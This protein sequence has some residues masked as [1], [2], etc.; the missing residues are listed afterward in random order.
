MLNINYNHTVDG[1]TGTL[2]TEPDGSQRRIVFFDNL[3]Y[4]KTDTIGFGTPLAQTFSF[5]R[6]LSSGRMTAR[7]D[8]LGRR[9]TYQY[10]ADGQP[11]QITYLAGTPQ[12]RSVK[13]AYNADSD[14]IRITDPLNRVTTL[15]YTN[16]CLTSIKNPLNQTTKFACNIAGQ[17]TSITDPLNQI[18][19]MSYRDYDLETIT[20]AL[21]RKITFRYDTLGRPVAVQDAEG[22]ISRRGYDL[23]GNVNKVIDPTGSITN[24]AFDGN[25]NLLAV[26]LPHGNGVT[27]TYDKRDRL[28]SRIDGLT[29]AEA[30]TY[31]P[32][33]RVTRYTDRKGQASSYSYDVL[34]RPI[35]TTF[36]DNTTIS[37]EYDA[38]DRL[39]KLIDSQT[40]TLSWEYNSFDEVLK[41][42]MP[43]GA[44]T[45]NYDK[46]GRR[47]EMTPAAQAKITYS[48]D[49]A[50]RLTKLVQGSDTVQHL[51]DAAG[52]MTQTT[53]PNG[54]KAGYAYNKANQ[55]T[56]IAWLKADGSALGDLGYG[57]N[58]VGRLVAQTGSFASQQLPT[59]SSGAN[60]FD[61]NQRQTQLDGKALQYDKNGN[62]TDDGTRQYVWNA[63]DQLVQI[64]QGTTVISTFQYD[65]LGRRVN[66]VE[67][68]MNVTYL[69]DGADPVQETTGAIVNPI[70]TGLGID[71][72]YARNDA[73]GRTYFLT[74]AL[75][76]TRALTNA[77][78]NI[79]NRY[80][81]DVY[82]GS[83]KQ[84]ASGFSNPYQYTGRER[85]GSG[86]YYYRARYYRAGMSN[87][88]GWL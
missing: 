22:N 72:R 50:D 78:G 8:P 4:P 41:A 75:G 36:A 30:W 42:T 68:A 85:D 60:G 49:N 33:D 14:L 40:G 10:N 1:V 29:Q 27:Y 46:A 38:G 58:T 62:L 83:V 84:S 17:R 59:A 6:D 54:V 56:G 2:V 44:I 63:R 88:S 7:I 20:D 13:L 16:R 64:K 18:T 28:L 12:A 5:E 15:G 37:A 32:R 81:Y 25:G 76:S 35:K 19:R 55:V 51:Y 43:Q 69:H 67:G 77:A 53:L 74:D 3:P 80:D 11:T 34:G 9:T 23:N 65:A 26:Q 48:Y 24:L 86:L 52:R 70:L 73:G 71:Q 87:K 82:G 47:T 57:Y 31:D 45:Y 61:D 79:V 21:G 39:L 66:R